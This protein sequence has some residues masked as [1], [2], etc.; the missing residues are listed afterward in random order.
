MKLAVVIA[1][2]NEEGNIGPLTSR[3]VQTLGAMG[4]CWTLI[5]V[6]EGTDRTCEIAKQFAAERPEIQIIYNQ[7]PSGLGGAFRHGFNAVP[8]DAGLVI[9]MD[10]D[11]NHQ[12]EEIPSL[13][14]AA[15]DANVDI[16]IGSRRLDQSRTEGSPLWKTATSVIVS[17]LMKE[18][19]NVPVR[20][21][22]S[23]YRVYRAEFLRRIRFCNDDFAFLPEILIIAGAMGGSMVERP[24]H[25]I[26]RTAGVSK[27]RLWTTARSY[28]RLFTRFILGRRPQELYT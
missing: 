21:M 19:F 13:V 27:M 2:Y 20:D 5:Y 1:A 8:E 18:L 6:I 23:G 28:V 22:T 7:Q 15:I 12:P 25:F 24:I 26:F 4:M 14:H 17:F 16:V 3:L 9:T 10:A 11:L